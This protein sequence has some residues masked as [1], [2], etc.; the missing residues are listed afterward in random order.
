MRI[1]ESNFQKLYQEYLYSGL[2]V[3]DFCTNQ[4]FA[5]STFYN[6]KKKLE[7]KESAP[8]FIPLLVGSGPI[9]TDKHHEVALRNEDLVAEDNNLEFTFPNGTKLQVKSNVDLTLLKTIVHLY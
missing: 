1:V 5:V 8:E 9:N 6:W 7:L 2:N 3:R 4:N